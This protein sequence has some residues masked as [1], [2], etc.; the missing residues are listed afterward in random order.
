MS[1]DGKTIDALQELNPEQKELYLEVE[2]L[3]KSLKKATISSHISRGTYAILGTGYGFGM[4]MFGLI[5]KTNVLSEIIA[6]SSLGLIPLSLM[7]GFQEI[8]GKK[9]GTY[10]GK[11][12]YIKETETYQSLPDLLKK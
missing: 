12:D 8:E 7:L 3:Q 2:E 5:E 9:I 1:I 6:I 10:Q 11:L 4:Y